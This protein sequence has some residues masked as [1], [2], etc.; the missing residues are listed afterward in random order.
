MKN[1]VAALKRA[2]FKTL[3]AEK[4]KNANGPDL[5]AIRND[6]VYTVEVKQARIQRQDCAQVHPVE[7]NRRN[8]DLIAIGFPSGNVLIEPMQDHL[9]ACSEKGWRSI[10]PSL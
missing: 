4:H 6:R 2:G 7:P 3:G 1:I 10:S 8:D 5:Y 9:R